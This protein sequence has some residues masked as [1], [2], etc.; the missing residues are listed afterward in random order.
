MMTPLRFEQLHQDEWSEL[1]I[2]IGSVGMQ[3]ISK[4]MSLPPTRGA[5]VALLY[6]RACE[7]LA[8]ARARAYP[9]Y[10]VDRLERITEDAHQLIY[11]RP[12]VGMGRLRRVLVSE[13]PAS[14]R[15]HRRYVAVAA[16]VFVLPMVIVG[17]LVYGRPELILSVVSAETAASFEDMYSPAA[18]S[19]GR[20]RTASTDWIM[21]GYY[22]RNNIGVSF[23]CFAGGLF[24]GLGTLFFLAYNGAFA[25]ALAGY[26][27]E[28]GMS[29][30][31]FSFVATHSAFEL[32]AIVLSGAAGLRIGH[33]L[34]AP[35]RLRRRPSLVRAAQDTAV[36][37]YGVV[38]LLVVAAFVE[39]FWS[40]ARWLPP[41]VKYAVAAICW[42]AVVLYLTRQGRD[43]A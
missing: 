22:I 19:I 10:I 13:F 35:G 4:S 25:G 8:L 11:H 20:V 28:R 6:R 1:E 27:A 40:S 42:T 41:A 29:A 39:A 9:A 12:E 34:L 26:L 36:L 16:A 7:H 24:A 17:A 5:R 23:Q 33:S 15:A 21:L 18:E 38:A 3:T 32:T 14:V 43:A 2:A 37:L 31:F 30:T